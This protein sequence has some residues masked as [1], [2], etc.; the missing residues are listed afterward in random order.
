[1]QSQASTT[2]E[3]SLDKFTCLCFISISVLQDLINASLLHFILFLALCLSHTNTNRHTHTLFPGAH[4][5]MY[6][7]ATH[8]HDLLLLQRNGRIRKERGRER[9][10][11]GGTGSMWDGGSVGMEEGEAS[12]SLPHT[13]AQGNLSPN[14][15]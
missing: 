4:Q 8:R 2:A 1:M 3:A 10:T 15:S 9:R 14:F 5:P 11:L 13:A 12:D 7:G 6:S